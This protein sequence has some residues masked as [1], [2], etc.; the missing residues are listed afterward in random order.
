MITDEDL[1]V[2]GVKLLGEVLEEDEEAEN[3]VAAAKT[4]QPR[5]A[6]RARMSE[7]IGDLS[8]DEISVDNASDWKHSTSLYKGSDISINVSYQND[9]KFDH[10]PHNLFIQ[11]N[12]LHGSG[13]YQEWR[14]TARWIKYEENV[15]DGADRW[16]RPHVSS[17]SFHS[18]L[19]TRRCLETG[20]VM[21]DLEE[22][23][24]AHIVYRAVE[25]VKS[26][27]NSPTK[28]HL[29][30]ISDAQRRRHSIR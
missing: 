2:Y 9:S 8:D 16:G 13:D 11:L 5:E 14:E 20:V 1:T 22:K 30:N 6:I 10:T 23:D 26:F 19:N 15:E 4:L 27:L 25:M 28:C 29:N 17:L 12:E 21:L 7:I 24:L 3:S 18:L